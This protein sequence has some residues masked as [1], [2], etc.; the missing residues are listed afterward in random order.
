MFNT[1][2]ALGTIAIQ[3]ALVITV[4]GYFARAPFIRTVANN[5]GL[6]VASIFSMSVIMSFI[7]QYGFGYEPCLLCW[8][9]RIFIIPVA[10]LAWTASLRTSRLLQNQVIILSGM[11]VLIALF[12]VI[13]DIFPTGL[14]VC[15][16]TGT[17]CL[18]RYVYEF[19]YITIPMMS[20][21]I[22]SAGLFLSLLAKYYPQSD[23]VTSDK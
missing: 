6:L 14:D 1:F 9:Q 10:L 7:Y 4:I 22:L 2:A 16:A 23:L 13:I 12:H 20:F 19:G 3:I 18:V 5:A 17:S 8:Y 21:T 11:G 15:G